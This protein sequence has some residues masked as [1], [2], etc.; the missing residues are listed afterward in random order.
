MAGKE[1]KAAK[2]GKAV[3]DLERHPVE[4]MQKM[5]GVPPALH[6]G[7]CIQ[8]GWCRGKEV[9]R[10]EYSAAVE[11]FKKSAAGRRGHA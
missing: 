7:T 6:T 3:E 4:Q 11:K 1:D 5:L 10:K 2:E 8:M 9:T